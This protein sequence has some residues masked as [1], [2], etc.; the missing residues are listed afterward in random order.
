MEEENKLDKSCI[1][2]DENLNVDENNLD[3]EKKQNKKQKKKDK[4]LELEKKNKELENDYLR[5]RADFENFR[6]RKEKEIIESKEKT[7]IDFVLD[8]L[9]SLD[10]FEMSLKMTDNKEM[11]IKGVEMINN[12]LHNLLN[13]KKI[14]S[15]K[16]NLGDDFD[17]YL[18][19]P[20]LIEDSSKKPG[21]VVN[22][23]QKGYKLDE[24]IIRPARVHV[25]KENIKE[26]NIE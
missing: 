16:A 8:L 18:H 14:F 5:L 2:N 24:K 4:I 7:I 23:L 1:L 15:F 17:P 11:F 22:V 20:V 9:P 19:E 13:Q 6:K 10:N 3:C 12:N 25:V 21:K 26:E